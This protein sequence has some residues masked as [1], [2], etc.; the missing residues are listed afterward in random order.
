MKLSG[1]A[2]LTRVAPLVAAALLVCLGAFFY[3][4]RFAAG[5]GV[6]ATPAA[7][8]SLHVEQ[9]A[10]GSELPTGASHFLVMG[11]ATEELEV[12]EKAPVNAS[13]LTALLLL[14]AF[15]GAALWWLLT[16]GRARRGRSSIPSLLGRLRSP[17]AGHRPR[18][19]AA[20][21]LGVFRL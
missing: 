9:D 5:T 15:L 3:Q 12:G 18:G 13:S 8:S 19:P 14:A 7:G 2:G 20:P 17:A 21:L 10:S 6:P 1:S 16:Y 4:L 11:V